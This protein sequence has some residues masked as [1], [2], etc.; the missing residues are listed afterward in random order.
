MH[1]LKLGHLDDAC[2]HPVGSS[3]CLGSFFPMVE[4]MCKGFPVFGSHPPVLANDAKAA[5]QHE[6]YL[7]SNQHRIKWLL[8]KEKV[9][10]L[11]SEKKLQPKKKKFRPSHK[12]VP[13]RHPRP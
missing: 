9:V 1:P 8:K 12:K 13:A 11:S 4:S 10:A 6:Y 3:T 5:L 7:Q 2:M